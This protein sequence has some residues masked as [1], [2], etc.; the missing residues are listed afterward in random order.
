M[1]GWSE[2][3]MILG[4]CCI[5]LGNGFVGLAATGLSANESE[6]ESDSVVP[7][8]SEE[9]DVEVNDEETSPSESESELELGAVFLSSKT[10]K[11]R[12]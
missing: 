1:D 8:E 7:E 9:S 10:P 4:G 3:S 5:R 2:I 6:S 11:L 12:F